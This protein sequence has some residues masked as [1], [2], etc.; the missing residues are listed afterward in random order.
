MPNQYSSTALDTS[1]T[2]GVTASGTSIAVAATTGFPVATP[3]TL[4]IDPGTGSEE[5]VSVT[6]V[7]GLTLTVTRAYDSTTGVTHSAGAVV[8]HVH[9]AIDF[10]NSRLHEAATSAVHGTTGSVVGTTQAQALT[11]KDLTDPTNIFPSALATD[12]E[13]STHA[14]LTNTHG[15][16]GNI[17]GTTQ[18]QTLTNKDLTAGTNTFPGTLATTASLNAHVAL[19]AAHGT[20]GA[21]VGT[22]DT[23]T[24]TN[25]NLSSQTNTPPPCKC[26]GNWTNTAATTIPASTATTIPWTAIGTATGG[27]MT[28][29]QFTIS[30]GVPTAFYL[31]CG[32]ITYAATS[33][34]GRYEARIRVNSTMIFECEGAFI[35]SQ[36]VAAPFHAIVQLAAGDIVD[37]Q[38]FQTS[39]G[40][41]G[42]STAVAY[43]TLQIAMIGAV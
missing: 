9:A 43:N 6:G 26:Y 29:G 11:N 42:L 14:G 33:A 1:L 31:V 12:A 37:I 15:V 22:T 40:S 8:R 10:R 27:T 30:A 5:L 24:L 23:Q 19:T 18:V 36:P 4:A 34:P 3:F 41:Q 7:S 20:V 32:V 39:T 25:K 35:N 13:L 16:T 28:G 2:G 38:A 21:V 17:V